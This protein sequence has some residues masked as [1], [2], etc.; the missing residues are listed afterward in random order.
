MNTNRIRYTGAFLL[1]FPTAALADGG[2]VS[3]PVLLLI[4][5][6][7]ALLATALKALWDWLTDEPPFIPVCK[8]LELVSAEKDGSD[9]ICTYKV[10]DDEIRVSLNA[11]KKVN[12]DL[13]GIPENIHPTNT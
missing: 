7:G 5:A 10:D 9:T 2:A 13:E 6:A 8:K 1:L 11:L 4:A 3:I 12:P